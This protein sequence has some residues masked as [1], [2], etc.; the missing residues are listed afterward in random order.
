MSTPFDDVIQNIIHEHY[1]NHRQQIHSDI[2]SR[3][4]YKDIVSKCPELREDI[5]HQVVRSWLNVASPTR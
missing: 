2:V 3:G 1:H 5:K 4:I